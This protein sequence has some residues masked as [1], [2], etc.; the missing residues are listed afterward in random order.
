MNRKANVYDVLKTVT[1]LLVIVGHV[2]IMWTDTGAFSPVSSSGSLAILANFIYA[3]HMPLFFFV[4]GA[5]YRMCLKRPG[6]YDRGRA[7]IRRKAQRLLVPYLLVGICYVAPLMEAM[8]LTTDGYG[9]FL[10]QGIFLARNCRHLWFLLALFWIFFFFALVSMVPPLREAME[11]EDEAAERSA[12]IGILLFLVV[13]GAVAFHLTNRTFQIKEAVYESQYFCMGMLAQMYAK[14]IDGFA[15]KY[16]WTLI[17]AG[18][19]VFALLP[20]S[21][22]PFVV[23]RAVLGMYFLYGDCLFLE[24]ASGFVT[25]GSYA[26]ISGK[27]MEIYLIHPMINYLVFYFLGDIIHYAWAMFL[28]AL[29]ITLVVS[30]RLAALVVRVRDRCLLGA[31]K[32]I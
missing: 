2:A 6:G 21:A 29:A 31:G 23:V 25:S 28:I 4:S 11:G 17:L 22:Y 14:R 20:L 7:L 9:R 16:K 10:V 18:L 3:F 26:A 32:D 12:L 15:V 1:T 8:H 24:R 19:L 5:V 30:E 27:A 13:I